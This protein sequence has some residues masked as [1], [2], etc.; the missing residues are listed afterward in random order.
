MLFIYLF[1][2]T[3]N[4]KEV[5]DIR[6]LENWTITFYEYFLLEENWNMENVKLN[7]LKHP[8]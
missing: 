3:I 2:N 5:L 7:V 1:S 8:K 4:K 6:Q